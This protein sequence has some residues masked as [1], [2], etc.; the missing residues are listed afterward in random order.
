MIQV[1]KFVSRLQPYTTRTQMVFLLDIAT[2]SHRTSTSLGDR[3]FIR[4]IINY[5]SRELFWYKMNVEEIV[6]QVQASNKTQ[7]GEKQY[8]FSEDKLKTA[9]DFAIGLSK[10]R[11]RKPKE[12]SDS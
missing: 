11:E 12:R 8:K 4:V 7:K 10:K 9:L 5:F 2:T 3:T 1:R 6:S